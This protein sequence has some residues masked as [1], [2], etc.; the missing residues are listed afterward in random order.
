M[1]ERRR[2]F[3]QDASEQGERGGDALKELI[4]RHDSEG[5]AWGHINRLL[6]DIYRSVHGHVSGRWVEILQG[7]LVLHDWAEKAAPKAA[8]ILSAIFKHL[9]MPEDRARATREWPRLFIQNRLLPKVSREFADRYLARL[10]REKK[11]KD[12]TLAAVDEYDDVEGGVI[13]QAMETE[14]QVEDLRRDNLELRLRVEAMERNQNQQ[15]RR[16]QIHD[17]QAWQQSHWQHERDLVPG[18]AA[19]MEGRLQNL[20]HQMRHGGEPRGGARGG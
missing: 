13:S 10:M 12:V 6:N 15:E 14:N 2:V 1:K 16:I 19:D 3:L 17:S 9:R 20:E 8:D 5:R 11:T 7:E 18:S 4:F